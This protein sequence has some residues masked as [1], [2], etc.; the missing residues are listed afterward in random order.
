MWSLLLHPRSLN[1]KNAIA[2]ASRSCIF[3]QFI[4]AFNLRNESRVTGMSALPAICCES[5]L[6]SC[7]CTQCLLYTGVTMHIAQGLLYKSLLHKVPSAYILFYALYTVRDI[8]SGG[9]QTIYMQW[10]IQILKST[11]WVLYTHTVDIIQRGIEQIL[12]PQSSDNWMYKTELINTKE[13]FEW[14]EDV[15]WLLRGAGEDDT[16]AQMF[17]P[18][19][20][21]V[22]MMPM[23]L[24][25]MFKSRLLQFFT[26]V[27]PSSCGSWWNTSWNISC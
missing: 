7:C 14:V 17:K 21:F 23:L 6:L 18:S 27:N 4:I 12:S 10:R 1:S 26:S 11:Q 13:L 3:A 15:I 8:H 25:K 24:L 22:P 20:S 2:A 9:L 5:I 19:A 16:R